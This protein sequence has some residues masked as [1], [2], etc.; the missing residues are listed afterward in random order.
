MKL[1]E[2]LLPEFLYETANTRK[3]LAAIPE[4]HFDY[5]SNEKAMSLSQLANHIAEIPT[6]VPATFLYPELDFG[7]IKYEAP[8]HNTVSELL[9]FYDKNIEE[10]TKLMHEVSNETLHENWTMRNGETVYFTMPKLSVYRTFIMNHTIHHRGQL[11]AYLRALNCKFPGM[12][13]P[14]A[15][16]AM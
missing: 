5:K 1:N 16:D 12:Y 13:G 9:A 3:L 7:K 2:F 11:T 14:T 8:N 10:A 15:D 6:W 4:E